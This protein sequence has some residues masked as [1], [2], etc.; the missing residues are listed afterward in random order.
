[1][2]CEIWLKNPIICLL[3]MN[4]SDTVLTF[5]TKTNRGMLTH[6]FYFGTH[7]HTLINTEKV[8]SY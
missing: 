1:M 8:E 4:L 7:E 6:L 3:A 5:V 2:I